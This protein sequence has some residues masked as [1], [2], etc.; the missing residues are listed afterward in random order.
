MTGSLLNLNL[1]LHQCRCT[2]PALT[3]LMAVALLE[4]RV[5]LHS[6]VQAAH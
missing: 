2:E 1:R 5:P 6:A 4:T 3:I